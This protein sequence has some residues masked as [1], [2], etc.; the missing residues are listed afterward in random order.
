MIL[1]NVTIN[2]DESLER[3]WVQWMKNEHIPEVM[4]TGKFVEYKM[5]KVIT[6]QPDETGV[7][8]SIQYFAK[9]L[10][11]YE[12]YNKDFGPALK[13]KTMQKYGERLAA[14]R[15]LLETV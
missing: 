14:F 15:T 11:D 12:S 5:F 6:R 4:Q 3:E 2:L 1:Y 13:M 8:Y 9:T 7:T 10:A